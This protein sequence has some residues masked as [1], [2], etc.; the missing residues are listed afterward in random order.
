MAVVTEGSTH[1]SQVE[2]VIQAAGELATEASLAAAHLAEDGG[3]PRFVAALM[4]LESILRTEQLRLEAVLDTRLASAQQE[5][6]V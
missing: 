6:T 5:L 1:Q 2:A 4:A 3:Q